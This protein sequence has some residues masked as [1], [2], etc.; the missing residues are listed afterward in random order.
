M[1]VNS[2]RTY[3]QRDVI[4][5]IRRRRVR[6][7]YKIYKTKLKVEVGRLLLKWNYL[8]ELFFLFGPLGFCREHVIEYLDY[9]RDATFID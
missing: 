4:R 6:I 7:L 2:L 5:V 1:N 3:T 8:I 9:I